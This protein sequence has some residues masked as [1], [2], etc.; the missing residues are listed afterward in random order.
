M[1]W[2]IGPFGVRDIG[3]RVALLGEV[4]DVLVESFP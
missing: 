1:P 2:D 4:S 3:Q